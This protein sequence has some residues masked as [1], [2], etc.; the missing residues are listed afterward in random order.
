MS[1]S[2][3]E[4]QIIE[5]ARRTVP[6]ASELSYY[7][8]CS[9]NQSLIKAYHDLFRVGTP[10]YGGSAAYYRA[11]GSQLDARKADPTASSMGFAGQE[12]MR[13]KTKEVA[14][15]ADA[16]AGMSLPF[17]QGIFISFV[18]VGPAGR[19]WVQ[20]VYTELLG[21][22]VSQGILPFCMYATTSKDAAQFLLDSFSL[23]SSS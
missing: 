3:A 8:I 23:L 15:V 9:G 1:R 11:D 4:E 14:T 16:L 5:I 18:T 7:F 21:Q 20:K 2:T 19:D 12:F 10:A 13:S 6:P 17:N 22:A